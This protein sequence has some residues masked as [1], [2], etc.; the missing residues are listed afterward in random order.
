MAL[1]TAAL[2]ACVTQ[3]P[4]QSTPR[5][6]DRPRA[7][8]ETA[9]PAFGQAC[10]DWD[11]WDK[12]APLVRIHGNTY[13]VGTCGI[14]AILITGDGG[15]VLIDSG[16]EARASVVAAN[17]RRLGFDLDDV[18]VL[19]HSHEH[20]DHV[21]GMGKLKSLTGAALYASSEASQVFAS[22]V[23]RPNDPQSGMHAPMA[24]VSVDR[25][26]TDGDVVRLGNIEVTAI[27]TPGHSPGA[28]SWRWGAC[29]QATCHRIV[30]ADSLSPVSSDQ[31][32]FSDDANYVAA[33]RKALDRV[34]EAPCNLLLTP[35]PSASDMVDRFAGRAPL[36]DEAACVNY[37]NSV[38]ARLDARLAKESE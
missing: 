8:I 35:H 17:I 13:Y 32:R 25:V 16:T 31:Y 29:E 4:V 37:A 7:P 10:T 20:F 6:V 2:S 21:G 28:M 15:H 34:A 12:P 30:Y 24:L 33:Y 38:R 26:I 11:D 14:A 5:Q 19:L 1:T 9:G 3:I 23:V 27:A 18:K 22:G 36:V